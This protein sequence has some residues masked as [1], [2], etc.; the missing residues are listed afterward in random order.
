MPTTRPASRD[1]TVKLHD[2]IDA[3][4]GAAKAA[5]N[6]LVTAGVKGGP[7]TDRVLRAVA[8]LME[9]EHESLEWFDDDEGRA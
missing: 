9:A 3:A 7:V 1:E 8:L 6:E 5:G 2:L 4:Y